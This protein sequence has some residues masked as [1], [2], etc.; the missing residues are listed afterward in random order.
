[1]KRSLQIAIAALS[2]FAAGAMSLVR[3]ARHLLGEIGTL[4]RPLGRPEAAARATVTAVFT[5]S[6]R[7]AF[8][9]ADPVP[10]VLEY[11]PG[12]AAAA[13]GSLLWGIPAAWGA[14][15]GE[16]LARIL[17]RHGGWLT[18]F[19]CAALFLFG[20]VIAA[21]AA[22]GRRNHAGPVRQLAAVSAAAFPAALC[23]GGGV[24][25]L[26]YYPFSYAGWIIFAEYLVFGLLFGVPLC[27]W[28]AARARRSPWPGWGADTAAPVRLRANRLA[29]GL[30]AAVLTFIAVS[31]IQWSRD[32]LP[33]F[34]PQLLG[35]SGG[36]VSRAV[37]GAGLFAAAGLLLTG[38]TP[39]RG[40][41]TR[42][43]SLDE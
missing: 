13:A 15:G 33:P 19:H 37:L 10:G 29:G 31:A 27:R 30:A 41:H 39:H 23:A 21:L 34:T 20:A 2:R 9:P 4:L 28:Y 38:L 5:L 24:D 16:L 8:S 36:A 43:A 42:P 18:F 35:T 1:M 40:A 26:G 17:L 7:V 22:T 11:D 6:L 32:R 14:A 3:G 12:I 25:L